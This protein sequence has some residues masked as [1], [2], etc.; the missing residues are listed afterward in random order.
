MTKVKTWI[1]ASAIVALIVAAVMVNV[2]STRASADVIMR[3]PQDIQSLDRRLSMVEQRFFLIETRISRIEQQL[4]VNQRTSQTSQQNNLDAELIRR[5]I[6]TLK[7]QVGAVSCG[8]ATL[9]E[10]TLSIA[11]RQ[12]ERSNNN[13]AADP[14]RMNPD[15]P[16]RLFARP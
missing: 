4:T 6:E 8:L 2:F 3:S 11:A 15:A 16:L 10:R 12:S 13:R 1:T 7:A 9:D 14:C 5:E